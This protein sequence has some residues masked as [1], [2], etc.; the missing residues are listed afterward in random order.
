MYIEST[1]GFCSAPLT[2]R[3]QSES[4]N[5]KLHFCDLGCKAN[6]QRLA[7]PVTRQWLE[8]EYVDLGRDTYQIAREV[9]RDP[10]SVWNWLKDFGIQTRGRGTTG[11][12]LFS[13]PS[14]GQHLS[15][16]HK[17]ALR[18][19]RK[20]SPNLPH[21][22][23]GVHHLKGK[24]GPDTPNWKGGSTPERQAFYATPEWKACVRAVWGRSE[25]ICER[26]GLDHRTV[27]R[28]VIPFDLHHVDSFS[29]AVD[30]R[31]DPNNVMLLC[32]PCHK[33]VHSKKN[34]RKVLLGKGN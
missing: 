17:Q 28:G 33:W 31:S 12:H 10:K 27:L 7:K 8:H 2:R 25:A 19:A 1:C 24:R 23:G 11:N 34:K 32:R 29:T 18:E 16:S 15:E 20:K 9:G 13:T 26:C 21:L 6:Y 30:R 3:K 4:A 5:V 14:R 22:T